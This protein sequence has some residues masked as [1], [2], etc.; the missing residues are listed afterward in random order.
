MKDG[1][2]KGAI[3][4]LTAISLSLTISPLVGKLFHY[5]QPCN[6]AKKKPMKT[7]QLTRSKHGRVWHL[8][9]LYINLLILSFLLSACGSA[10]PPPP[11]PTPTQSAQV[12]LGEKVFTRECGRCHAL[13][14]DTMIVGPALTHIASRAGTQVP[15]QDAATYLLTSIVRPQAFVVEGF[16]ADLMPT[17]FGKTL[18]GEEIDALVAF[19]LT[20]H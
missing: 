19:L 11:P 15:E 6:P 16:D 13:S 8:V 17:T 14:G 5:L 9:I 3:G 4:R 10:E 12:A 7:N 20:Q 18:T 1:G 2:A